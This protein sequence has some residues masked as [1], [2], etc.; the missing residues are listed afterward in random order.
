[1]GQE[2]E[3]DL[4]EKSSVGLS[5]NTVLQSQQ[6]S[7]NSKKRYKKGKSP[8]KDYVLT[9]KED[10]AEIK[11]ARFRSTSCKSVPSRPNGLESN[12]QMK[13]GSMYQSSEEVKNIKNMSTMGERK[14]IEI[15]R[16]SDISFSCSIV[17]SLCSS[18][19]EGPWW[20]SN[21]SSTSVSRSWVATEP[22]SPDCF[23]EICINSDVKN[24]NSTA[25][26]G[27]SSINSMVKGQ[28]VTGPLIGGNPSLKSDGVQALHKSLSAKVEKSRFPSPSESDRL[29]R[30]SPTV[31]FSPIRKRF[32][33]FAKSKSLRGPVTHMAQTS[34]VESTVTTNITRSRTY[35]KCLLNDFS[36]TA[37]HSDIISEFINRD[38][39]HS[40]IGCSPVHLHGNLKLENKHG[41]LFFEFKVK[42]PE[43][44]FVAKAWRAA[45]A[46]NSIYTFHSIDNR[47]KSNAGGL[48]SHGCDKDSSVVAQMQVSCNLCS[49]LKG[50]IFDNSMVTE[51]VLYDLTHSR[52]SFTHKNSSTDQDASKTLKAHIG[53]GGETFK[54]DEET[55][56]IK[57]KNQH[58]LPSDNVDFDDSNSY[59]LVSTELHPNLE[60]AAIVLQVP[61]RKIES[62]KYKI[63]NRV[64]AKAYP[65][66]SDLV[67]KHGE[68]LQDSRSLEQVKVVIPAGNHGLP[69]TESR[70]PS[71][72]L[73]RWRHGGGCDCGGWDMSC[74][75]I[76]LGNPGIQLAEDELL[77][78]NYQP[79]ELFVQGAKDGTPTFSMKVVEEGQYTVDFHA[80]LST[81]QAFSICIAILHGASTFSGVREE[82]NKQLSQCNSLKMLIEEEVDYLMES[83]SREEKKKVLP[84]TP[85]GVPQFYVLNPPF[86]PIARV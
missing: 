26:V 18:D 27:K 70:G 80:Q 8:G 77:M 33:P 71:S 66:L 69:N 20:N 83:V 74:P 2:I 76:L 53:L 54:L 7:L 68:S 15:A 44:I 41:M 82:K 24:K 62:L 30:A 13:R 75:L 37:K 42:C 34:E 32:N 21:L 51:F 39:Q 43:D 46:F 4:N 17:D 59:P 35:Q 57:S 28:K 52:E 11:F 81:L 50:G 3:L 78:E 56:A 84:K 47:K 14:K 16:S 12:I 55:H 60:I 45:N 5:P 6:Y 85:K 38:I 29:S 65:S 31:Q 49:E 63:G 40:G 73:D 79:L 86:S 48:G 19:D 58:K 9:L 67:D 25:T 23:I 64:S 61:F 1:M 36:N 72:L 22:N 10:F